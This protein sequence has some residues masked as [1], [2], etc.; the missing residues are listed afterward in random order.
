MSYIATY[1]DLNNP[2]NIM[3]NHIVSGNPGRNLWAQGYTGLFFVNLRH[4]VTF[5]T[6]E[7][8]VKK[9]VEA[10]QTAHGQ[11]K[12][13][14]HNAIYMAC[15]M[16]AAAENEAKNLGLRDAEFRVGSY[17]RDMGYPERACNMI[18]FDIMFS[19]AREKMKKGA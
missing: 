8:I 12:E 19:E 4:D 2:E 17:I 18:R 16:A 3:I 13:M 14:L 7:A 5:D 9:A 1:I 15:I 11:Y 6:A 10:I